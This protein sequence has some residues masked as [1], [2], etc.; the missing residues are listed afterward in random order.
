MTSDG[1]RASGTLEGG[2]VGSETGNGR[3]CVGVGRLVGEEDSA[4]SKANDDGS[5]GRGR[6]SRGG[7]GNFVGGGTGNG[8]F[9]G[10]A[11]GLGGGSMVLLEDAASVGGSAPGGPPLSA[12]APLDEPKGGT[13]KPPPTPGGVGR[14]AICTGSA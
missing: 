6:S 7:G 4:I 12:R 5:C 10:A 1:A 9:V 14:V 3:V 13:T 2:F 8:R 11:T